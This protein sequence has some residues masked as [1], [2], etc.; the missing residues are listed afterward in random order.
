MAFQVRLE[1]A[2]ASFKM[3]LRFG[4]IDFH[5]SKIRLRNPEA[6]KHAIEVFK[7]PSGLRLDIAVDESVPIVGKL[8][9]NIDGAV[10]V[11]ALGDAVAFLPCD[12][13]IEYS[14]LAD[15][16]CFLSGF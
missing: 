7:R 16:D 4:Q 1:N 6:R 5:V 3:L 15:H 8:S 12:P 13:V 11:V 10:G 2:N 14:S 9:R